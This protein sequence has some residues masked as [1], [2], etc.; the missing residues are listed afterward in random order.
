MS[1]ISQN[2]NEN[3]FRQYK[4]AEVN[5]RHKQSRNFF[6]YERNPNDRYPHDRVRVTIVSG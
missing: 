5:R 2:E 3:D 6:Y 4:S 1:V